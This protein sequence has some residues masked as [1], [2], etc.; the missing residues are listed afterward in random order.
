[1]NFIGISIVS[2]IYIGTSTSLEIA[3]SLEIR[4]DELSFLNYIPTVFFRGNALRIQYEHKQ[5]VPSANQF[6]KSNADVRWQSYRVTRRL[7][8]IRKTKKVGLFIKN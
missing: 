2:T 4:D 3:R 5:A 8:K 7:V 6:L 1:V